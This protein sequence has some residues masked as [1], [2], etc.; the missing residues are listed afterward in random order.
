MLGCNV[1]SRAAPSPQS[2][3]SAGEPV[4]D[5]TFKSES[6]PLLGNVSSTGASQSYSESQAKLSSSSDGAFWLGRQASSSSLHGPISVSK[7]WFWPDGPAQTA[8]CMIFGAPLNN[9]FI[10]IAPNNMWFVSDQPRVTQHKRRG[11]RVHQEKPNP[12]WMNIKT[13]SVTSAIKPVPN[14][15]PSRPV[16]EWDWVSERTGKWSFLAHLESTKQSTAPESKKAS[17][18]IFC[19]F[20]DNSTGINVWK[21]DAKCPPNCFRS[22]RRTSRFPWAR[23]IVV[24][25][26][27]AYCTGSR[28]FSYII[29]CLTHK[30]TVH[31]HGF[32]G[33]GG[34]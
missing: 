17:A 19:W 33:L 2:S 15:R 16:M 8:V 25:C 26:V 20:Q 34:T 14:G 3:A 24:Q 29:V 22:A 4:K 31:L 18:F 7:G 30:L 32:I 10:F 28:W 11:G 6:E 27:L 9:G 21:C 13:K 5:S 23:D 1:N 12:L